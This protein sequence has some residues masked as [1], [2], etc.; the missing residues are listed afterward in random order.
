MSARFDGGRRDRSRTPEAKYEA[1]MRREVRKVKY[2]TAP[3][4]SVR[5]SGSAR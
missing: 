2:Q 4:R 1:R 3:L 5:V